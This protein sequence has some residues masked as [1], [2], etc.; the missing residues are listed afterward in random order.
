M[1]VGLGKFWDHT[2]DKAKDE[3][4]CGVAARD[5]TLG[6]IRKKDQACTGG[7]FN[8]SD[9]G[10]T[11]LATCAHLC[12]ASGSC[13]AFVHVPGDPDNSCR[14]KR[15]CPTPAN[16]TGADLYFKRP[17]PWPYSDDEVCNATAANRTETVFTIV[18][19][20]GCASVAGPIFGDGIYSSNSSVCKAAVH[21]GWIMDELGGAVTVRKFI[22]ARLAKP[23]THHG[24]SALEPWFGV[25][26]LSLTADHGLPT[27][28]RPWFG[29]KTLSLTVGHGLPTFS[30]PWFGVKTL[31]HIAGHG[32]PIFSRPCS[33]A[34]CSR[35]QSFFSSLHFV[36]FI[37]SLLSSW[38]FLSD[39]N[40]P[41][42]GPQRPP[43]RAYIL[44][45]LPLCVPFVG[46]GSVMTLASRTQWF[47]SN[48]PF[49][50]DSECNLHIIDK[51]CGMIALKY[52]FN[53][54]GGAELQT[55]LSLRPEAR[56]E[57]QGCHGSAMRAR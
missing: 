6:Y 40:G 20:P 12:T 39:R 52:G 18:C 5:P 26:T 25:K 43:P 11:S 44:T 24:V 38:S 46:C 35:N 10:H 17:H 33:L 55:A 56:K 21:H 2:P 45:T 51:P 32:L 31:S 57:R 47:Y 54:A 29:V 19:P 42:V 15:S 16:L 27:F 48:S 8:I 3:G 30:R 49:D 14:L 13:G 37:A 34:S 23:I 7:L 4:S 22:L 50:E 9:H 36:L 28:S 1:Y 53:L 41:N